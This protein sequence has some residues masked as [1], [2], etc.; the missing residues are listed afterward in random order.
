[1]GAAT[2]HQVHGAIGF[3]QEYPLH[4]FTR[5]LIAWRAE[6]GTDRFWAERLGRQVA[7]IG[8]DSVWSELVRRS[9]VA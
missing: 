8:A 2:A 5:R 4:R 7:A 1:V 3:T 6:F 9:Q